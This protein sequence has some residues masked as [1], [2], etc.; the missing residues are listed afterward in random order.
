M[1]CVVI[2]SIYTQ[3]ENFPT[4]DVAVENLDLGLDGPISLTYLNYKASKNQY[5]EAKLIENAEMFASK[6]NYSAIFAKIANGELGKGMK[7]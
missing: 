4:A 6:P 7:M 5:K 3:N 1:R 2:K